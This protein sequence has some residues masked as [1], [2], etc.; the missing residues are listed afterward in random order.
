M[1]SRGID[2]ILDEV[3]R[4]IT[5]ILIG[6][7]RKKSATNKLMSEDYREDFFGAPGKLHLKL[8]VCF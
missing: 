3:D 8:P 2:F 6:H 7:I 1:A 4:L 5:A